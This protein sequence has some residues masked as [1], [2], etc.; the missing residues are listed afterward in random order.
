MIR[1]SLN[2]I[3]WESTD[4]TS[5]DMQSSTIYPWLC[6]ATKMMGE[7]PPKPSPPPHF[8]EGGM[9]SLP[10][11][12]AQENGTGDPVHGWVQTWHQQPHP[13]KWGGM[14]MK[15]ALKN[16]RANWSIPRDRKGGG[17]R[18]LQRS[19]TPRPQVHM[20]VLLSTTSVNTGKH[21]LARPRTAAAARITVGAWHA[22]AW[23]TVP[24]PL[25]NP[26]IES[27][28]RNKE[29]SVDRRVQGMEKGDV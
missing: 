25:S 3:I 14:K 20:S 29:R 27:N 26:N 15:M 11:K 12:V 17:R 22:D 1:V 4:I 2:Y 8:N 7:N 28:I 23:G 13:Q 5:G 9:V 24:T 18:G 16:W 10:L 19:H 6:S 21:Q